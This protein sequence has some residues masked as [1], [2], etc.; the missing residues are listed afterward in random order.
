MGTTLNPRAICSELVVGLW[1]FDHGDGM[2]QHDTSSINA[3]ELIPTDG[4]MV[5]FDVG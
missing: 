1:L 2:I 3:H 5:K 4:Q